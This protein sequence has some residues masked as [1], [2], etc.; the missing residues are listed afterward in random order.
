MAVGFG[1]DK[2]ASNIGT[3]SSDI[4]KINGGLYT[5]GIISG[6]T[7]SVVGSNYVVT[8]GVM[9][10]KIT[11]DEIVLAPV[12]A[13][14]IPIPTIGT[15]TDI[16]YAKQ[17]MPS[18]DGG[19]NDVLVDVDTTGT[20]PSRSVLLKK[21]SVSSGNTPTINGSVDYSIPYGANLGVLHKWQ[22]TFSGLL[23]IPLLREG[24]GTFTLPT[25]RRVRI[26]MSALLYANG[27]SGFSDSNY[28]EWYFL[29]NF[30]GPG[31]NGDVLIWT[32][33]GLHQAWATYNFEEYINLTA[34]TYTTSLGAGRM[35]GPG[36]AG[37]FYGLDGNGFGRRGVYYQVEDAGPII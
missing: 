22:N 37:T 24:H 26:S 5:P 12:P 19:L 17:R 33:P 27:A 25:D 21:Y 2:N 20:L 15:R 34:G 4:R 11:T 7:V 28:T 31:V 18:T 1:V 23:S 36:Q 9:A 8:S 32:T 10:V 6:C 16:V 13:K 29:P 35:V 3:T 30:Q 14:T